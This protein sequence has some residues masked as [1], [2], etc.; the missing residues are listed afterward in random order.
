MKKYL[1]RLFIGGTIVIMILTMAIT[2][3]V[4][5]NILKSSA[6]SS[7]QSVFG[8]V[9]LLEAPQE[10]DCQAIAEKMTGMES[11]LE[12]AFLREDGTLI[13]SAPGSAGID[14][15]HADD[16]DFK[17]ALN[18]EA[19]EAVRASADSG[20]YTL[21]VT[22][23]MD[24][25]LLLRLGYPMTAVTTFLLIM[26]G[27]GVIICAAM[28][29]LMH[30]QAGRII[31]RLLKPFK[32]INDQLHSTHNSSQAV[33][34]EEVLEE[35]QP[36]MDNISAM[37]RK[38]HY[39]FEEIQ[40]TQQLRQNFV[41]N[42]SH[43]LKTPLITIKNCAEQALASTEEQQKKDNLTSIVKESTRLLAII[44][45]ILLLNRAESGR[46]E[47]VKVVEMREVCDDAVQ[48]LQSIAAKKNIKLS[49]AGRGKVR[50]NEKEMWELVYNLVDNG[51]RYGRENG[52][53]SVR[54]DHHG[55]TVIDDGQGMEQDQLPHIF[56]RF[57]RVDN[58]HTRPADNSPGGT[59]LGLSIVKHIAYKY[60]GDVSVVSAPG[61]GSTFTVQLA[62]HVEVKDK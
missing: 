45:D 62:S 58:S 1:R 26:L 25:G 3:L 23:R 17:A 5:M 51:I 20:A 56:E 36:L 15:G 6:R 60:G 9:A 30:F 4:F 29:V 49:V 43:E 21:Y 59:G 28:I 37:I 44:E 33:R 53:V 50:A 61:E 32:Q 14:T 40:R 16:P 48:A 34:Q 46:P 54:V 7:L 24:N 38:L 18:G 47:D 35:V 42:A 57:Y 41:A 22:R 10:A 2:S 8:A 13:A 27:A 19:G 31:D 55:L 39:D 52:F 12:A 11:G